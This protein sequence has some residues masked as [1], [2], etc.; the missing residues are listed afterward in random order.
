MR[1]IFVF[2][3]LSFFL[4]SCSLKVKNQNNTGYTY[5]SPKVNLTFNKP[6]I[7]V[8]L[9]GV[10]SNKLHNNYILYE[11]N[12]KY[13]Y[14]AY[15]KWINS[16]PTMLKDFILEN[17]VYIKL[18]PYAKYRLK[19]LLFDFEPHFNKDNNF[20]YFKARAFFYNSSYELLSSKIFDYK[21]EIKQK[22][23]E[24]MLSSASKATEDFLKNLNE[25]LAGETK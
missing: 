6:G 13:D 3:A 8:N 9:D 24:S 23:N 19:V 4:V 12:G 5:L 21:V 2:L 11:A 16:P 1:K 22:T 25:W 15:S 7:C 20:F 17:I 18:D 10:E 14:F